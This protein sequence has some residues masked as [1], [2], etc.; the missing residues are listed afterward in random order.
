[1]NAWG[2]RAGVALFG[3]ALG[4]LPGLVNG[5]A[6]WRAGVGGPLLPGWLAAAA[7]GACLSLGYRRSLAWPLLPFMLV[8]GLLTQSIIP[9]LVA[10][11]AALALQG[12]L[13]LGA[14]LGRNEP[15]ADILDDDGESYDSAGRGFE[16]SL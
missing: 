2:A 4:V 15:P 11:V 5:L 3:A 14:R 13:E 1:M 12:V 8:T 7:I 6:E 9:P 16:E 10:A